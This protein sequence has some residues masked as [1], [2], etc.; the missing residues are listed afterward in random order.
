MQ[1]EAAA[2]ADREPMP[3][4]VLAD[5]GAIAR[6]QRAGPLA[7]PAVAGQKPCA[8]GPAK[9]HRSCE[10]GLSATVR[11][12]LPASSRTSDLRSS[13]SGNRILASDAG[14]SAASM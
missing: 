10:S 11:P 9:K 1:A 7:D 3:T 6:D 4:A 12:A 13:P 2:L 14:A 5:D 8:I